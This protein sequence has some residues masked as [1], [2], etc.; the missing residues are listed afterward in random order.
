MSA[1]DIERMATVNRRYCAKCKQGIG[2]RSSIMETMWV[3]AGFAAFIVAGGIYP[4]LFG[5]DPSFL[6]AVTS[7]LAGLGG[8]GENYARYLLIMNLGWPTVAAVLSAFGARRLR[9]VYR[10]GRIGFRRIP[11][12]PWLDALP[13]YVR[14]RK[15][16]QVIL[17]QPSNPAQ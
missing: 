7:Q 10:E 11:E 13:Y 17:E 8:I 3:F 15:L 16:P 9:Q 12:K 5:V 4:L 6:T 1:E 14:V 2:I